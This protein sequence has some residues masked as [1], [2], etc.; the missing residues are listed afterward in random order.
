MVFF[1]RHLCHLPCFRKRTP[2]HAGYSIPRV[3]ITDLQRD[4]AHRFGWKFVSHLQK[5]PFGNLVDN[6]HFHF[7]LQFT[8]VDPSFSRSWFS[9]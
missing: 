6:F 7:S 5:E 1:P 8:V 3:G 4:S 9:F 2:A